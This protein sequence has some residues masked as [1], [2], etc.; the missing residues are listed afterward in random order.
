MAMITQNT[1]YFVLMCVIL[2]AQVRS[3]WSKAPLHRTP[4]NSK[5]PG[6]YLVVLKDQVNPNAFVTYLENSV[7]D[8]TLK[9]KMSHTFSHTI[10]G[11]VGVLSEKSI[12]LLRNSGFVKYVE[13]D[14][15]VSPASDI[16]AWGLDRV[17]QR[18]LPLDQDTPTFLGDGSGVHIYVIDTGVSYSHQEFSGRTGNGVDV[19]DSSGYNV[20]CNGHGTHCAAIA[21][22]TAFGV[23]KNATIHG[24]RVLPCDGYGSKSLTIAG[25]EW[26]AQN[27]IKP[28]VVSMSISGPFSITEN[29]I[30]QNMVNKDGI[31]VSVAAGNQ[32]DHAC[33]RS[34]ASAP[35]ALT[36][37]GTDINDN[38]YSQFN[39][40]SCVDIL[41]PGVDIISA[42]YETDVSSELRTGTSQAC[43][44][45]SGA[46][47]ILLG[48]DNN[49]N[50]ADVTDLILRGSTPTKLHD[51]FIPNRLLYIGQD[52]CMTRCGTDLDANH[53]CQCDSECE[54]REDC[55]SDYSFLCWEKEPTCKDR[56]ASAINSVYPCQCDRDCENREDCCPD[57]TIFCT[58]LTCYNRCD[59]EM[60]STFSCQCDELCFSREDCCP[61]KFVLCPVEE[62]CDSTWI[63]EG[64]INSHNFPG[65]YL[66]NQTCRHLITA[67]EGAVVSIYI[68]Y[69]DVLR[70]DSLSVYDGKND[71]SP[72]IIKDLWGSFYVLALQSSGE[73]MYIVFETDE[74][75]TGPGFNIVFEF[76]SAC[77]HKITEPGHISSTNFPSNYDD[78]ETC[79]YSIT[80]PPGHQVLFSFKS[81]AIVCYDELI[82]F[83]SEYAVDYGLGQWCGFEVPDESFRSSGRNM[84]L[85]FVSDQSET[86]K[87]FQATVSFVKDCN[88]VIT[89]PGIISSSNYPTNYY[90]NEHCTLHIHAGKRQQVLLTLIDI[91]LERS[92]RRSRCFDS[93]DVYDANYVDEEVSIGQFCGLKSQ[94][95]IRSSGPDMTIVFTTDQSITA[96]G[97]K[98]RVSFVGAVTARL[99][100]GNSSREGTVQLKHYKNG[101]GTICD[102]NWDVKDASVICRMLG[103]GAAMTASKRATFGEGTGRVLLNN[104]ECEGSEFNI[105]ECSYEGWRSRSCYSHNHDAGAVCFPQNALP[106]QVRLADSDVWHIGRVEVSIHGVWGTVC[107]DDFDISDAHVICK[108]VGFVG[109]LKVLRATDGIKPGAPSLPIYFDDVDCIGDEDGLELCN[110][111][112]IGNHNCVHSEDVG[113]ECIPAFRS[114]KQRLDDNKGSTTTKLPEFVTNQYMLD[115][116]T[117][118]FLES[119]RST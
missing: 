96:K 78:N 32:W 3:V 45:V 71:T 26:V 77:Q 25:L 105:G 5:I 84:T 52:T 51:V 9:E 67:P 20:D 48:I 62:L 114:Q 40:G 41:A 44:H 98:A 104:V 34:P 37:G 85:L 75:G 93:L 99:I 56:C 43:P 31:V 68:F 46:A 88:L 86:E 22:G 54:S 13:E 19:V 42:A 69:F 97:Y 38:V 117:S 87:G 61:D 30:I 50:P 66:N 81:L 36:V 60:N 106:L 94:P 79:F 29:E 74:S 58:G 90:N 55:C 59:D 49:L 111:N 116:D 101:R 100:G 80:A 57:V 95:P 8:E 15:L 27:A 76:R 35:A 63:S 110:H 112:G 39:Y 109:A 11:F 64:R 113:V 70:N 2:I 1:L 47:A 53:T 21:A 18:N 10:K 23:A 108:H 115:A 91:D 24:V 107:D 103:Y 82:L 16:P 6:R 17:D 73:D 33:Y 7:L 72:P 92:E 14:G 28:A 4:D 119:F 12:E 102:S 65:N 89:S 83:D 118:Q